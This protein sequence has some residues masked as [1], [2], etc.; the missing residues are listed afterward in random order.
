MQGQQNRWPQRVTTGSWADSRQILQ[1]KQPML[2]P[3]S[4][5]SLLPEVDFHSLAK[6]C[7][8]TMDLFEQ[9]LFRDKR[10]LGLTREKEKLRDR[11]SVLQGMKWMKYPQNA[12][13]APTLFN[14]YWIYLKLCQE[15]KQEDPTNSLRD[16]KKGQNE[17]ATQER[18]RNEGPTTLL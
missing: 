1:S 7:S 12:L 17:D 14:H 11:S 4:I 8:K 3:G 2:F 9:I 10:S 16:M 13:N 15:S 5:V 6:Y 18:K